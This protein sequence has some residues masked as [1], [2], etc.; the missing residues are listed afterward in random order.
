MRKIS[1]PSTEKKKK[2][3]NGWS[4]SSE[5]EHA[6]LHCYV[7]T[8]A[9]NGQ[10]DSREGLLYRLRFVTGSYGKGETRGVQLVAICILT[11]RCH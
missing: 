3:V 8:L 10:A 4:G 6:T 2:Y 1:Y 11:A 7:P 9:M 5:M